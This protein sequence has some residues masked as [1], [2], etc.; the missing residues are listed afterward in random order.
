MT[1]KVQFSFST[2]FQIDINGD[3]YVQTSELQL[4]LKTVGIELPGYEVRKLV[5]GFNR[6]G[7][8]D[9]LSFWEFSEVMMSESSL[10]FD[11]PA[12]SVIFF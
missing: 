2:K 12:M 9:R 10:L 7:N 5:E 3:G 8:K 11:N 1:F 4:A 6:S